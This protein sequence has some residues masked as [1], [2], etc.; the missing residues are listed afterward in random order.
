MSARPFIVPLTCP[1]FF[2]GREL[3]ISPDCEEHYTAVD[4]GNDEEAADIFA[5]IWCD[6]VP[7]FLR[8]TDPET[9]IRDAQEMNAR[10]RLAGIKL[11]GLRAVRLPALTDKLETLWEPDSHDD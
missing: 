2:S 8:K 6:F 7:L 9:A 10:A 1:C 11:S 3:I 4:D 5:I